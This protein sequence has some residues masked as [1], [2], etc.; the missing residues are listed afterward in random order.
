MQ[1]HHVLLVSSAESSDMP[2]SETDSQTDPLLSSDSR[3]HTSV[4]HPALKVPE[5]L[6]MRELFSSCVCHVTVMP[7]PRH[8]AMTYSRIFVSHAAPFCSCHT[9]FFFFLTPFSP[10][11][12]FTNPEQCTTKKCHSDTKFKECNWHYTSCK[13]VL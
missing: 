11:D 4:A 13:A 2:E 5:E 1:S 7:H 10:C 3:Y 12:S 6:K 8:S 9:I